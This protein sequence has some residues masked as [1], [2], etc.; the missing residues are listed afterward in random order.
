[1][2]AEGTGVVGIYPFE[3]ACGAVGVATGGAH[4][5]P[6]LYPLPANTT[7]R[8]FRFITHTVLVLTAAIF[9]I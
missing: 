6:Q 7:Y 9:N 3:E 5:L 1:M 4:G 2:T 8:F